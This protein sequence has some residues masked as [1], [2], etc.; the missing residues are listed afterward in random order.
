[1]MTDVDECISQ[2]NDCEQNCTNTMGSFK[3]GCRNGYQLINRTH[4]EGTCKHYIHLCST[5][6]RVWLSRSEEECPFIILFMNIV[7][8]L[9]TPFIALYLC[10]RYEVNLS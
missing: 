4:C 10:Y 7:T 1:M 6:N 9:I 3:C 2:Q 8:V 5:D